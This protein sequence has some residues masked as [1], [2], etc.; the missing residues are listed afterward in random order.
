M[1]CLIIVGW[2]AIAWAITFL[3]FSL[4]ATVL[5]FS[6]I[7]SSAV[8]LA[9]LGFSFA[10]AAFLAEFGCWVAVTRHPAEV[11]RNYGGATRIKVV[12]PEGSTRK[13][14]QQ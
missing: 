5:G 12:P 6:D 9:N 11:S 14:T 4:L 1:I 7:A 13:N 3:V 10:L 8:G 2:A